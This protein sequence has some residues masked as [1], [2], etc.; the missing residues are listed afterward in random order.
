VIFA[1]DTAQYITYLAN[2]RIDFDRVQNEGHQ[3]RIILSRLAEGVQTPFDR[4]VVTFHTQFP[5][6]FNLRRSHRLVHPQDSRL[7]IF[8][9]LEAIDPYNDTLLGFD[10]PLKAIG[11]LL[12]LPLNITA[13][14]GGQGTPQSVDTLQVITR[15]GLNFVGEFLHVV[16]A[17]QRI[18]RVGNTALVSDDLLRAQRNLNRLLC[19]QS[20]RLIH[21][22]GMQAL[23]PSQNSRQGLDGD[24]VRATPAVW[25]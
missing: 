17:G 19:G 1:E 22:I 13:L 14:N 6:P 18:Y 3:I 23:R 8:A 24:A 5:Q 20:Q 15:A 11:T 16:A 2:G 9:H 4:Q 21:T 25:V 12:N 10:C 7:A